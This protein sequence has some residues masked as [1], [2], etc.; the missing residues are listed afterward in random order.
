[1]EPLHV[2]ASRKNPSLKDLVIVHPFWTL[3][4]DDQ[5]SGACVI[6]DSLT[7]K[8]LGSLLIG[9]KKHLANRLGPTANFAPS[10]QDARLLH[11]PPSPVPVASIPVHAPLVG[12]TPP[13]ELT[14]ERIGQ[15]QQNA[16]PGTVMSWQVISL[17]FLP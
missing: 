12:P 9:S 7:V 16:L 14:V 4:I 8:N 17:Q 1:M 15:F 2:V 5:P 10:T 13:T 11:P 6:P 3:N